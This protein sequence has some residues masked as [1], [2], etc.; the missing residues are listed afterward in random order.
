MSHTL[1]RVA[2]A[3]GSVLVAALV[4]VAT[5]FFTDH[6]AVAWWVSGGVLL[7]VGA[8]VQWFLP[9]AGKAPEGARQ[10]ATGNTVGGS[11]SQKAK[12]RSTQEASDNQVV[13]DLNQD[14]HG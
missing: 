1:Q 5:G 6:D 2:G 9:I 11:L 3:I 7:A 14:Q 8:A 10:R 12:G 4:N 13:G